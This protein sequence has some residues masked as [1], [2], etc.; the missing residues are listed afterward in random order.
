MEGTFVT[1]RGITIF[2]W[3]LAALLTVSAAV[4]GL[5]YDPVAADPSGEGGGSSSGGSSGGSL[6]SG[7]GE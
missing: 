5:S 2:A 7:S 6:E 3:T 1:K 4:V